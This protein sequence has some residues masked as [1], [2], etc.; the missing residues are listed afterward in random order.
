M[1]IYIYHLIGDQAVSVNGGQNFV[2]QPERL[3]VAGK[4]TKECI[5]IKSLNQ[6]QKESFIEHLKEY[7][8]LEHL[9]DD[10][11]LK[12]VNELAFAIA[13]KKA[14]DRSKITN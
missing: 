8:E 1:V 10:L 5:L 2:G 12:N 13:L 3:K 6:L 7:P 14:E 9:I 11:K 4:F